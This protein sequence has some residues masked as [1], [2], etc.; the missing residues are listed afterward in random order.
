MILLITILCLRPDDDGFGPSK[1]LS[2]LALCCAGVSIGLFGISNT[3]HNVLEDIKLQLLDVL[4]KMKYEMEVT[5]NPRLFEQR[6]Y[7]APSMLNADTHQTHLQ[8]DSDSD[9]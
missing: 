6:I 7:I 8:D 9:D 2:I 5:K 1:I 3:L 4:T